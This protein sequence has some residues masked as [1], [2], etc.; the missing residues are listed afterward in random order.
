MEFYDATHPGFL[1]ITVDDKNLTGEYF[2]VPFDDA[3]PADPVDTFTLNWRTH[4][5]A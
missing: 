2:A 4:K 5:L 1:R 3:P